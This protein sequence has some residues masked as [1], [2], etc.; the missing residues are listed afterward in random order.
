[1]RGQKEHLGLLQEQRRAREPVVAQLG[2]VG[3]HH[4]LGACL[5]KFQFRHALVQIALKLRVAD[6]IQASDFP[7]TQKIHKRPDRREQPGERGR[8]AH[9]VQPRHIAAGRF[10]GVVAQK[11]KVQILPVP[12]ETQNVRLEPADATEW[13]CLKQAKPVAAG[14]RI[15]TYLRLGIKCGN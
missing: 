7:G 5:G 4:G 10:R 12:P 8:N 11:I 14:K 2:V 6:Q 3:Q 1:M 9:E 15:E 13:A